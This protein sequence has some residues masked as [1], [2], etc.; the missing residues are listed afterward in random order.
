MYF[1]ARDRAKANCRQK[2]T[3][4]GKQEEGFR[5]QLSLTFIWG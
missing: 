5:D 4:A 1:R 3:K 2:T